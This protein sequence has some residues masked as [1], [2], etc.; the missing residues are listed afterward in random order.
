[1]G[2]THKPDEPHH[3]GEKGAPA[4]P[5]PERIFEMFLRLLVTPFRMLGVAI[6][7]LFSASG[8]V[9]SIFTFLFTA[10]GALCVGV[11]AVFGFFFKDI[12]GVPYTEDLSD[13]HPIVLQITPD[14]IQKEHESDK[15]LLSFA[16]P[17][18]PGMLQVLSS[19]NEAL[20]DD[21]LAGVHLNMGHAM[22]SASRAYE[23][24][25]YL[26]KLKK[27]GTRIVATVSSIN[28]FA[29]LHLLSVADHIV[30]EPSALFN[31]ELPAVQRVYFKTFLENIG[32]SFNVLRR[33]D[34]KNIYSFLANSEMTAPERENLHSMVCSLTASLR[35]AVQEGYAFNSET[36][37]QVLKT[38]PFS[39]KQAKKEMLVHGVSFTPLHTLNHL[40]SVTTLPKEKMA[41]ERDIDNIEP[42]LK[43]IDNIRALENNALDDTPDQEEDQ[44]GDLFSYV[45]PQDYASAQL[46]RPTFDKLKRQIFSIKQEIMSKKQILVLTVDG[47][48]GGMVP[49]PFSSD[50]ENMTHQL[51]TLLE[52]KQPRGILI[53]IN[54]SGGGAADAHRF[55]ERLIYLK[56]KYNV[57]IVASLSEYAASGGYILACSADRIVSLPTTLTGSIGVISGS[58]SVDNLLKKNNISQEEVTV[59]GQPGLSVIGRAMTP[60]QTERLSRWIDDEYSRF[61]SLVAKQ[62]RMS[63]ADVSAIAQGKIWTGEQ[64]LGK[65]LVD[66]LGTFHDALA[67]LTK[68]IHEKEGEEIPLEVTFI[69]SAPTNLLK[70]VQGMQGLVQQDSVRLLTSLNSLKLWSVSPIHV[71]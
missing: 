5:L 29:S 39:A 1:M 45:S 13:T 9:I 28:T 50:F 25:H 38:I 66:E 37:D 3:S 17:T 59:N 36:L 43:K 10:I 26:E 30:C 40:F 64:A 69:Q 31:P 65:G 62:R 19:L 23:L 7:I 41:E 4:G 71:L 15:G 32:V 35:P 20:Q 61:L 8:F 60:E 34:Y 49:G 44:E 27:K 63:L 22:L 6:G 2:S 14:L 47:L 18:S 55:Y 51:E 68:M 67:L 57:P 12:V 11:I 48:I 70:M 24:R 53:R 33:G 16:G 58:F 21:K 56:K 52:T 42:H 54:S 46:N